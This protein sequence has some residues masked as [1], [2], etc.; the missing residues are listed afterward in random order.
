MCSTTKPTK[1]N[2]VSRQSKNNLWRYDRNRR[3]RKKPLQCSMHKQQIVLAVISQCFLF[4]SI[5]FSAWSTCT[6]FWPSS[7]RAKD[8][9]GPM[10]FMQNSFTLPNSPKLL[11]RE[12]ISWLTQHQWCFV[13][14]SS[15]FRQWKEQLPFGTFLMQRAIRTVK[16]WQK[17]RKNK[18]VDL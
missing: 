14:K 10:H 9:A 5:Q 11:I 17:T 13:W 15:W 18:V 16:Y 12:N 1:I 6:S 2:Y 8:K 7:M 4:S 3:L